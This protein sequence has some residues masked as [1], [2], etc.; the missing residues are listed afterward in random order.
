LAIAVVLVTEV[1][2]AIE[3]IAV[4]LAIVAASE[5]AVA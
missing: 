3:A 1:A 2:L 4:V 5:I